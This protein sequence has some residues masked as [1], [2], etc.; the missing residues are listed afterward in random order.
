MTGSPGR[1]GLLIFNISQNV[2]FNLITV[3][4]LCQ[5]SAAC[6]AGDPEEGRLRAGLHKESAGIFDP[7]AVLYCFSPL[8][9]RQALWLLR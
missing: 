8:H 9:R 5:S 1:V 6:V 7:G 4:G 3:C 2:F